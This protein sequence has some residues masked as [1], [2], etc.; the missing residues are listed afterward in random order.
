MKI[1][2]LSKID[3]AG[4]GHK[5]CQALRMYGK[6]DIEIYTGKYYNPF[7]HPD[8][9]KWNYNFVQ[10]RINKSD[11]VHLKGD[12]PPAHKYMGLSIDHKPIVIT[13]SGSHFRKKWLGGYEKH[14]IQEYSQANIRTAFTP[15]LCYEDF[16]WIPHPIDSAGKKIEWQPPDKPLMLH[17]PTRP[18]IK[19]TDFVYDLFAELK[20]HGIE[21]L[22]VKDMSFRQAVE[23]R[24]R[25]TIFFDQFKVG[26]YGNSAIEAMQYGIPVA[27]WIR[28]EA[29][30]HI[31]GCPVITEELNAKKYAKKILSMLDSLK[32]ISIMTKQWC[33]NVHGYQ[34]VAKR[35]NEIYESV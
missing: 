1:T 22:V 10:D 9:S 35:V 19:G 30:K 29:M 2:M 23:Y 17:M 26:F 28:P 15:D 3:Y 24:K 27:A 21:V 14:D 32:V 20:L 4:S 5:L 16:Q 11:I 18:E 8:N 33:D 7:G 31:H 6:H 25:A 13:V 34:A 12:F